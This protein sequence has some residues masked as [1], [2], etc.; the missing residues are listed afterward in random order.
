MKKIKEEID[1]AFQEQENIKEY[2][3][4]KEKD[5]LTG[6]VGMPVNSLAIEKKHVDILDGSWE[7]EKFASGKYVIY[8]PFDGK[9]PENGLKAG[10]KISIPF[11]RDD[12]KQYVEKEFTVLAVANNKENDYAGSFAAEDQFFLPDSVIREIYP[13]AEKMISKVLYDVRQGD[14][15]EQT[16]EAE[17][18]ISDTFNPQV[19]LSSKYET[20]Q[21][22]QK[23]K[24]TMTALGLF[25][26]IIFGFIGIA[27]VINTLVTDVLSR[28]IEYAAMQSIG[29]TKGQ[30]RMAIGKQGLKLTLLSFLITLPISYPVARMASAPPLST[31]FVGRVYIAALFLVVAV[32]VILSF[33][34]AAVLTSYLNRKAVVERLREA[35]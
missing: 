7:E 20:R 15:R 26:G 13:Q 25:V 28:K 17:K 19:V 18:I 30:L 10:E 8:H 6:I 12:V 9:L 29:M 24:N 16:K 23:K 5:Y 35:E 14:G 32:G 4:T 31:G 22:E 3:I 33:G 34:T 11:Y 2:Y 21:S 27:N 1:R